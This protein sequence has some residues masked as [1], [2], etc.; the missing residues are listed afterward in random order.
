[1]RKHTMVIS[2]ALVLAPAAALATPSPERA[3]GAAM[4]AAAQQAAT[5]DSRVAIILQGKEKPKA[6]PPAPKKGK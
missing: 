4:Q 6:P 3:P 1:M 2:A 5:P